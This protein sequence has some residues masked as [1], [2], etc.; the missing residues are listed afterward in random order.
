MLKA[1]IKNRIDILLV[2]E[3][4][5]DDSCPFLQFCVDGFILPCRLDRNQKRGGIILYIREEIS[6]KAGFNRYYS[7]EWN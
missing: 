2:S 6:F 7:S 5:I 1:F 3:T 4:K